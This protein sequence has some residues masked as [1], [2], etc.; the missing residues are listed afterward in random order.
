MARRSSHGRTRTFSAGNFTTPKVSRKESPA[1]PRVP[2]AALPVWCCP[3]ASSSF[4]R[5]ET[6][7]L[8]AM[9]AP[10]QVFQL[11]QRK[12]PFGSES[13]GA[14]SQFDDSTVWV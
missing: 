4:F 2:A 12:A 7:I 8:K 1:R 13:G 14:H 3:A 11:D 6:Q 9:Q 10:S 5:S